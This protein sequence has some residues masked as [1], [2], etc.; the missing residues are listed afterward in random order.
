MG[1]TGPN[2]NQPPGNGAAASPHPQPLPVFYRSVVAVD[3]ARHGGKSLKRI[4]P[5]DFAKSTHAVLLNGA[6]FE[7]AAHHF[8]I[9]FTSTPQPIALALL[10][11]KPNQNLFLTNAG[12]WRPGTYVPAY[13]RRLLEA[14]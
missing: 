2:F 3:P 14:L 12:E 10:G 6:E 9:V 4:I 5:L 11:I 8:P 13:V 7:L 1:S